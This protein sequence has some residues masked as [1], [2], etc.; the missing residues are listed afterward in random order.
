MTPGLN[1]SKWRSKGRRSNR[2][3]CMKVRFAVGAEDARTFRWTQAR[4]E[5]RALGR[6]RAARNA[7]QTATCGRT[8][9]NCPSRYTN[10]LSLI[11]LLPSAANFVRELAQSGQAFAVLRAGH[12]QRVP[13][14]NCHHDVALH[15]DLPVCPYRVE[16]QQARLVGAAHIEHR[17]HVAAAVAFDLGHAPGLDRKLATRR[18]DPRSS[19][20]MSKRTRRSA[21]RIRLL[22]V[23]DVCEPTARDC[24]C[25]RRHV[26]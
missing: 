21:S 22:L 19:F 14:R 23:V 2:K 26:D 20:D 6:H 3:I 24:S 11:G 1:S 18:A 10:S 8:S 13:R 16:Q 15:L 25:S 12:Q 5:G 7:E 4:R 17:E 9:S